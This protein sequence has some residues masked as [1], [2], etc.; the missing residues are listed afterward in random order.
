MIS[1]S[2]SFCQ[3]IFDDYLG[4]KLHI[5]NKV[6]VPYPNGKNRPPDFDLTIDGNKYSVEATDT[7]IML[8]D[9]WGT[10]E[11]Q[12]F[13]SSRK[14]FIMQIKE[15]AMNAGILNGFY[16]VFSLI[17]WSFPLKKKV[18]Q[19]IKKSILDY[20]KNTKAMTDAS[21]KTIMKDNKSLFQIFKQPVSQNGLSFSYADGAWP[22]STKSQAY[23]CRILQDAIDRK[24]S[25]LS[26]IPSPRILLVK[27][28]Y[29]FSTRSAFEKCLPK[30]ERLSFYHSIYIVM[31]D[32]KSSFFLYT[33]NDDWNK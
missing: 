30:L 27:N 4:E 14:E 22:D 26:E 7:Q 1:M 29:P 21:P 10:V 15:E 9:R 23:I 19:E 11:K 31:D 33:G 8:D 16:C 3:S 17:P 24:Y 12:T 5:Q 25:K 2:E 6:W 18:K 32:L 13:L 20:I 28:T